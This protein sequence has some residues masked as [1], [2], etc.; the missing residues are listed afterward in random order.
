MSN[1]FR[2]QAKTFYFTYPKCDALPDDC[3]EQLKEIGI[4]WAIIAQ[5][6]HKDESLHLHMCG[7]W[8][9][10][11]STRDPHFFDK[12][13][14]QHGNYQSMK[15]RKECITYCTKDGNYIS[16]GID[17]DKALKGGKTKVGDEVVKMIQEGASNGEILKAYP[18]YYLLQRQKIHALR[19]EL[20][21]DAIAIP[22]SFDCPEA[23]EEIPGWNDVSN[24][25]FDNILK[26][27]A[28]KQ[29]QLWIYG[30]PNSGKSTLLL[31]LYKRLRVYTLSTDKWDD[32]YDDDRFDLIVADEFTGWKTVGYLNNISDGSICRLS[33]RGTSPATKKV[34]L[35]VI[36]CSN[37]SID[38]VYAKALPVQRQALHARFTQVY[39]ET[40]GLTWEEVKSVEQTPEIESDTDE[41]LPNLKLTRADAFIDNSLLEETELLTYVSSKDFNDSLFCLSDELTDDENDFDF[42]DLY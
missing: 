33:R 27:R 11:I 21:L 36:I 10:K 9:K 29:K 42:F 38:Q 35:P 40:P 30:P 26:A 34:N 20:E 13:A 2:Y 31:E 5:E 3:M 14:G 28:F 17:V 39:V 23:D 1:K 15:K 22:T 37:L 19:T 24:W 32:D 7:S 41:D 8:A 25:L 18:G 12:I 6:K 16:F 4:D